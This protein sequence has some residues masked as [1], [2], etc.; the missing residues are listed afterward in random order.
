MHNLLVNFEL[1]NNHLFHL[2]SIIPDYAFQ[3]PNKN[4]NDFIHVWGMPCLKQFTVCFWMRSSD[5]S[6]GTPFSYVVSGAD[7]ELIITKYNNFTVWVGDEKRYVLLLEGFPNFFASKRFFILFN[8]PIQNP[9]H[10]KKK[11]FRDKFSE[12]RVNTMLPENKTKKKQNG[13]SQA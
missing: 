4:V 8:L 6:G 5:S 3:F 11:R 13:L 2:Y 1:D 10:S 9:P 7:K 12:V